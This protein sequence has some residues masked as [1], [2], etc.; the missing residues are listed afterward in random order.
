MNNSAAATTPPMKNGPLVRDRDVLVDRPVE[1]RHHEPERRERDQPGRVGVRRRR[2]V[3]QHLA[4]EHHRHH[5]EDADQAEVGEQLTAGGL[6]AV[7]LLE[8][9]PHRR[10]SKR[11]HPHAEAL[12]QERDDDAEP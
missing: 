2:G 12:W 7:L 5:R 6:L 11:P 8:G 10:F 3:D 9:V 4:G 1:R